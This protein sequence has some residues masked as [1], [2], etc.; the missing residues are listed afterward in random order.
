[1]M[2]SIIIQFLSVLGID[3][4]IIYSAVSEIGGIT[5][6]PTNS[7]EALPFISQ[8]QKATAIDFHAGEK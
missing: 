5:Y 7:T 3:S 1:M 4:L 6:D 2:L 8:I